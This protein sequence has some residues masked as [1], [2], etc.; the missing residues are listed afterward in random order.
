MRYVKSSLIVFF[1]FIALALSAQHQKIGFNVGYGKTEVSD[2]F[3]YDR[4]EK[5]KGDF[6]TLEAAYYYSPSH[7]LID[8]GT[9][10]NFAYRHI[11]NLQLCYARIPLS[12]DIRF[13]GGFQPILGGGI[14]ANFLLASKIDGSEYA[15]FENSKNDFQL[16]A[17]LRAGFIYA[18]NER[19]S[20]EM[21]FTH[22]FDISPAFNAYRQYGLGPVDSPSDFY[23][24]ENYITLGLNIA[25]SG[26]K[27][28]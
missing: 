28:E 10:I 8:L 11:E 1:V 25:L 17:F 22:Q 21:R 2:N 18:L 27:E 4:Y 12:F 5:I 3:S 14:S 13:G 16:G 26:K 7:A 9:G 23:G 19:Y 20:F 15:E 6:F 24:R